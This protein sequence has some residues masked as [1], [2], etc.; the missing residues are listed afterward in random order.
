MRLPA[1][2]SAGRAVTDAVGV[3]ASMVL[4]HTG[5]AMGAL[6]SKTI[7]ACPATVVPVV[8]PDLAVPVHDTKPS[9]SPAAS[10]GGRKPALVAVSRSPVDGSIVENV[11]VITPFA[12]VD[13]SYTPLTSR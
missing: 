13:G 4:V 6:R 10:S 8:R 3:L 1:G 12:P 9:P 5:V 11:H 2:L 7:D